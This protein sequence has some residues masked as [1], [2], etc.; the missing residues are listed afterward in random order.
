VTGRVRFLDDTLG[1]GAAT[2][3]SLLTVSNLV[4]PLTPNGFLRADRHDLMGTGKSWRWAN[5]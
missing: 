1:R 2:P 5:A 4:L 3:K